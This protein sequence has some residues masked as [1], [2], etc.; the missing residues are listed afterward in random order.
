MNSI[1]CRNIVCRFGQTEA[2]GGVDL[3][4]A[5]GEWRVLAGPSGSGKT[6]LLRAVAGLRPVESGTIE[7]GGEPASDTKI[8]IPP[9]ARGI[10]FMFQDPALWPHLSVERNVALGLPN[11]LKR[12]E[13]RDRVR[14]LLE[15][16]QVG[17]LAGRFPHQISGGQAQRVALARCLAG[18]PRYLLLDEPTAHLDPHLRIEL[19]ELLRRVHS[20]RKLTTICVTHHFTPRTT[21]EA[22]LTILEAGKVT[23]DGSAR[24][25]N[26]IE[27]PSAYVRALIGSDCET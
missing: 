5:E 22:R 14:E 2:L 7:L 23:F 20:E 25:L 4:V 6:T 15:S 17:E 21:A 27:R 8:R 10:A 19:T 26:A 9:D 24:D 1:K 3:E 16:M 12:G 11:G 13:R 18:E